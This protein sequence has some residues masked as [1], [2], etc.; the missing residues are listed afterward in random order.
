MVKLI[1][2]LSPSMEVSVEHLA[3]DVWFLSISRYFMCTKDIFALSIVAASPR[4]AGATLPAT[5][6]SSHTAAPT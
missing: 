2:I 3:V 5:L 6:T 4:G 1:L